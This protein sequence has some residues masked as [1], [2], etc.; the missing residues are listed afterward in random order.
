[1]IVMLTCIIWA[2]LSLWLVM[3]MTAAVAGLLLLRP[4]WRVVEF[5][6]R[7]LCNVLVADHPWIVCSSLCYYI[8]QTLQ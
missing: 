4:D 3:M 5:N 1:M 2:P 8:N 6:C 7:L